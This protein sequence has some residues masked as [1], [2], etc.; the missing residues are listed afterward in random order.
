MSVLFAL[1]YATTA[2]SQAALPA[3]QV[4]FRDLAPGVRHATLLDGG[5]EA[6]EL[7]LTRV[8]LQV[9]ESRGQ[10]RPTAV[11]ADLAP[12]AKALVAVNGG[13]FDERG[14]P[15]GLLVSR[16][17][18]L[19]R[20]R[21]TDWGVFSVD[22]TGR[23]ELVHTRDYRTTTSPEFAVQAG[24]RLVVDGQ[25]LKLKPQWDRRTAIGI[26]TDPHR[27]VIIVTRTAVSLDALAHLF[28]DGLGCPFALNLDGG[29]STQLWADAGGVTAIPGF[30]VAN[31]VAVVPRAPA[32]ASA[33]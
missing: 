4:E 27:V 25:I 3:T 16:G 7:D 9:V 8:A 24:P 23:A 14:R 30:A 29:S 2:S 15:L 12:A 13:Y 33:P 17:K 18:L 20:L 31:A 10:G 1:L 21:R 32:P 19:N 22:E 28:K 11:V 6:F 26:T 5:A